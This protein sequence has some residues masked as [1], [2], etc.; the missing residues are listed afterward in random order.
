MHRF[1][2][3]PSYGLALL[4]ASGLALGAPG[5][6]LA[7]DD[8]GAAPPLKLNLDTPPASAAQPM[9]GWH[10][11]LYGDTITVR[12]EDP[13]DR[14]RI[15]RIELVGPGN[16]RIAATDM[17]REVE[18]STGFAKGTAPESEITL[19]PQSS[20][21]GGGAPRVHIGAAP[22]VGANYNQTKLV[23]TKAHVRVPNLDSYLA[24]AV[25]WRFVVR[26]LDDAGKAK[27]IE[28][29]APAAQSPKD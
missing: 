9:I 7:Q 12:L 10:T 11:A 14:Y 4:L 8:A 18:H 19:G 20:G 24:S 29:A 25:D 26:L 3:S 17:A 22:N 23:I 27:T 28:F 15:D 1:P 21:A 6:A 16:V 2:R 13:G 5:L